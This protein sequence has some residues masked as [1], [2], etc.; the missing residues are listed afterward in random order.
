MKDRIRDG[1]LSLDLLLIKSDESRTILF[2]CDTLTWVLGMRHCECLNRVVS[3][4]ASARHGGAEDGIGS[5][6]GHL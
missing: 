2:K 5:A 1:I 4:V 3:V 6:L